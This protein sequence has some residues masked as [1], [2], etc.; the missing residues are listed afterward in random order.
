MDKSGLVSRLT[1]LTN[2]EYEDL[3]EI[4]FEAAHELMRT[5]KRVE[6]LRMTIKWAAGRLRDAGID[7]GSPEYFED[8]DKLMESVG[9][10]EP[11]ASSR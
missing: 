11:I 5:V 10:R 2:H 9:D 1:R 8:A 3:D 4:G 7:T 6:Q